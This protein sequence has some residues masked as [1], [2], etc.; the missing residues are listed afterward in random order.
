M[1]EHWM[2]HRQAVAAALQGRARA[3]GSVV[4]SQVWEQ[5]VLKTSAM[6]ATAHALQ[7]ALPPVFRV[8][9]GLRVIYQGREIYLE[10]VVTGPTG[11]YL[12][13]TQSEGDTAW[14]KD[15]EQNMAFFRGLLGVSA[16][17]FAALVVM[18]EPLREPLPPGAHA[19]ESVEVAV[20]VMT[21]EGGIPVSPVMIDQV[22][23]HLQAL[24]PA[25]TQAVKAP[26]PRA[27]VAAREAQA[28]PVPA[29]PVASYAPGPAAPPPAPP[30]PYAA[31]D[32][33][34]LPQPPAD[35][36]LPRLIWASVILAVLANLSCSVAMEKDQTL[37][38]VIGLF[39]VVGPA[40][41]IAAIIK[42]LPWPGARRS[43]LIAWLVIVGLVFLF[44]LL[45]AFTFE[46]TEVM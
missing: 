38:F 12:L 35:K 26:P 36:S 6:T 39:V 32:P 17:F 7:Q 5:Y 28:P 25:Q 23:A 33:A 46:P 8:A 11:I 30:A 4:D 34:T 20:A 3:T 43:G 19:V 24:E 22:W 31:Y 29:A 42:V 44:T 14:R 18:R 40:A 21:Q 45:M 37:T 13:E 41:G 16:H 27:G 2:A 1:S 10:H 15:L 9:H